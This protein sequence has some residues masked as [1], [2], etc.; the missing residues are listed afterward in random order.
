MSG[1][2]STSNVRCERKC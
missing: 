1:E 2:E